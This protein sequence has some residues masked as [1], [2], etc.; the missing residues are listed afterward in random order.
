[1]TTKEICDQLAACKDRA[2]LRAVLHELGMPVDQTRGLVKRWLNAPSAPAALALEAPSS[3]AGVARAFRDAREREA[4]KLHFLRG[5]VFDEAHE[6]AL[7]LRHV[8]PDAWPRHVFDS[9]N[10]RPYD[11]DE[12]RAE[13]ADRL[14]GELA[15]E[16]DECKDSDA[17]EAKLVRLDWPDGVIAKYLEDYGP[18]A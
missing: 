4:K 6:K 15:A 13:I 8:T 2:Q 3:R 11:F 12:G 18:R 9:G 10:S 5:I 1:M 14:A 7:H 16:L 17:L